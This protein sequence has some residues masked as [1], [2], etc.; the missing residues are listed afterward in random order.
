MS[1]IAY[2]TSGLQ[3]MSVLRGSSLSAITS[4]RKKYLGLKEEN[5]TS[6]ELAEV[7]LS[8]PQLN[9]QESKHIGQYLKEGE[10]IRGAVRGTIKGTGIAL[11]VA[12]ESRVMYL[13]ETPRAYNFREY[14]YGAI[15]SISIRSA[16]RLLS[17]IS[18]CMNGQPY[19]L[20]YVATRP[21]ERF[22]TY[23][24]SHKRLVDNFLR[25]RVKGAIV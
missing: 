16:S 9:L 15:D 22:V 7:G 23:V 19:E 6:K 20:I 3:H 11:I 13:Q 14:A 2:I 25:R 12:T 21:A 4:R 24:K 10:H 5:S 1:S 18:I 8:Y 17:S